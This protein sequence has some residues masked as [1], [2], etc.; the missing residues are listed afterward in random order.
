MGI[1]VTKLD[2]DAMER[3]LACTPGSVPTFSGTPAPPLHIAAV[4]GIT[5][6]PSCAVAAMPHELQMV[7]AGM[8]PTAFMKGIK[9]WLHES[10]II[11]LD[12]PP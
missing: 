7:L 8:I 4:L 1:C 10:D 5:M 11:V 9:P 12:N 2:P 3:G 6:L